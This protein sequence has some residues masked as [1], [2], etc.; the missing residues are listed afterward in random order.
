MGDLVKVSL[1]PKCILIALFSLQKYYA[2]KNS[3][4]YK[5]DDKN[6]T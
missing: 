2:Q 6:K 5:T 3:D 4:K 1:F